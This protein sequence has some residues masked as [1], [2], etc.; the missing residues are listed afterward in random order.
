MAQ[1]SYGG[2]ASDQI[3]DLKDKAAEQFNK[4][5]DQAEKMAS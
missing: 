5:A 2:R 3:S 1:S 4:A